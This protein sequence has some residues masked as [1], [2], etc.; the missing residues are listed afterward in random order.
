M[1]SPICRGTPE[2]PLDPPEAVKK[3]RQQEIGGPGDARGRNKFTP[4]KQALIS[5]RSTR[6]LSHKRRNDHPFVF[7]KFSQVADVAPRKSGNCVTAGH[8]PPGFGGVNLPL[9]R[10]TKEFFASLSLFKRGRKWKGSFT[11]CRK[12][13]L[14]LKKGGREGFLGKSSRT[15]KQLRNQMSC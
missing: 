8:L 4:P 13:L 11:G 2:I 9:P 10:A 15:A 5:P 7:I 6:Y 3:F 12:A 14:P 1:E